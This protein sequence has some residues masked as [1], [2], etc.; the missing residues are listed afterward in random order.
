MYCLYSTWPASAYRQC[1]NQSCLLVP[2]QYISQNRSAKTLA[3]LWN[4]ATPWQVLV[5]CGQA[6][7]QSLV[8]TAM[9]GIQKA[10]SRPFEND[11]S[12]KSGNADS[13][14]F[15][16]WFAGQFDVPLPPYVR[17]RI[18]AERVAVNPDLESEDADLAPDLTTIV[19]DK[20][21]R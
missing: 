21:Q 20:R 11:P 5:C 2:A 14:R 18:K 13:H 9:A 7:K 8:H 15:Q 6:Q 16:N 17:S 4:A 3:E 1:A 12:S 19:L 10:I